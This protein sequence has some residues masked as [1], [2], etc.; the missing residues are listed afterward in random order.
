MNHPS[1]IPKKPSADGIRRRGGA[2]VVS[3][4][5]KTAGAA[6]GERIRPEE[7]G[8]APE[9]KI[10]QD[11]TGDARENAARDDAARDIAE[12]PWLKT[13]QSGTPAES[14]F[15]FRRA[16]KASRPTRSGKVIVIFGVILITAVGAA[17]FLSSG[18]ARLT[19]VITPQAA[20][21]DISPIVVALT[22]QTGETSDTPPYSIPAELLTFTETMTRDFPATGKSTASASATGT[23]RIYNQFSQSPQTLVKTTRFLSEDGTLY[24]LSRTTTVPGAKLDGGK[25][26]PAFVEAQ[27]VADQH[28]QEA[29]KSGEIRLSVP[30]FKGTPREKGFYAIAP[31][32]FSGGNQ[33]DGLAVSREDA[34]QASQRITQEIFD[35]LKKK[36]AG[37]I[38]DGFMTVAGL[39]EIVITRVD[40]PEEGTP[41]ERFSVSADAEAKTLVFRE[42]DFYRILGRAILKDDQTREIVRQA[43]TLVSAVADRDFEKGSAAVTVSG[44]AR[45]RTTINADEIRR[46]AAGKKLGSLK[47]II[48]G[49]FAV[50]NVVLTLFPPWRFSAPDDPSRIRVEIK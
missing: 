50:E 45:T 37:A 48:R 27:L 12:S 41:A 29:N 46:L 23:I 42:A 6:A 4:R 17:A 10:R 13:Y 14:S 2:P 30:G 7:T 40:T 31:A 33:G 38:P 1:D 35:A 47:N 21:A 36:I 49:R 20:I 43:D 25:L 28:G 15:F 39:D 32:G 11:H 22:T 16:K 24:R 8:T 26:V 44:R 19:I 3:L 5:E 18:L 9:T 34:S